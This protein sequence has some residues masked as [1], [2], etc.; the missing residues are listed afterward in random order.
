M[1]HL[2][3]V[4]GSLLNGFWSHHLLG[5]S[6]FLGVGKTAPIWHMYSLGGFPGLVPTFQGEEISVEVYK[7]NDDVFSSL[8]RLEG[9]DHF[10]DRKQFDV[11]I[12]NNQDLN[13]EPC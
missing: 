4:Y 2:V 11:H 3:A 6:P 9:Y 8:D 1:E 12:Q 13:I 5:N 7:V 10:Y